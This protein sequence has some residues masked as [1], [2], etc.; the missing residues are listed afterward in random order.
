MNTLI[1]ALVVGDILA[2]LAAASGYLYFL[3]KRSQKRITGKKS[4]TDVFEE[5][6]KQQIEKLRKYNISLPIS[7]I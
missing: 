5:L 1:L 7:A 4:T 2:L 3:G 6:G